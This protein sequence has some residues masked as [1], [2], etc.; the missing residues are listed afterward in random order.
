MVAEKDND[1]VIEDLKN[2]YKKN[3]QTPQ[4]ISLRNNGEPKN[5]YRN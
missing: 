4:P 2:M 5:D 3:N 1:K